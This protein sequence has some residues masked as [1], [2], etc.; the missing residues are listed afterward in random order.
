MANPVSA[1][2]NPTHLAT[3]AN[4]STPPPAP[5][6]PNFESQLCS[7]KTRGHFNTEDNC[8]RFGTCKA[9]A[10]CDITQPERTGQP[11]PCVGTLSFPMLHSDSKY[12]G[13]FMRGIVSH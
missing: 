2:D 3:H 8:V 11:D 4:A 5:N 10:V 1:I 13:D 7:N 12:F 6:E 9:P